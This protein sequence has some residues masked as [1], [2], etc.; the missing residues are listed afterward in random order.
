MHHDN[1]SI[2]TSST[3]ITFRISKEYENK[4]RKKAE[5]Q[6][7]SLNTL[8]N[9]IFQ[10]YLESR[11]FINKF[12]T[13]VFSREA[14]KMILNSLTTEDIEQLGKSIGKTAPKEFILFKWKEITID[15][16]L[17]FIKMFTIHCIDCE[18][19]H[20]SKS[21][22][23]IFSIRHEFG[24]K[25]SI[26]LKNYFESVVLENLHKRCNVNSTNNLV[27]ITF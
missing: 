17:K 24:E 21:D 12:G 6:R 11:E 26:F 5:E 14:F 27:T 8:A 10:D 20:E 1:K 18:Y 22:Q 4:L 25:G 9:Q 23:Q 3:T 19:D 7:I 16:T 2:K 15:T 13:V